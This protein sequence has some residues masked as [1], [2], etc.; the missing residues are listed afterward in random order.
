MGRRT[1]RS[2]SSVRS[3]CVNIFWDTPPIARRSS[4]CRL[5][6]RDSSYRI[7]SPHLVQILVKISCALTSR[8]LGALGAIGVVPHFKV[9][10]CTVDSC[11]SIP[12]AS[13]T[14]VCRT[15]IE[16]RGAIMVELILSEAQLAGLKAAVTI[17]SEESAALGLAQGLGNKL[18]IPR[19]L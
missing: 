17:G 9:R 2:R 19:S 15:R 13:Q 8:R 4:P 5:A 14:L 1:S 10:T 18:L 3:V 11:E 16:R 7:S 12:S 6:P